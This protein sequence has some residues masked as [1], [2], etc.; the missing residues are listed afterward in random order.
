MSSPCLITNSQIHF[1]FTP[2]AK[3]N[4]NPMYFMPFGAGPRN[5]IGK[6]L[7]LLQ[8]KIAA[9]YVFQRYKL[10]TCD[11]S[12]QDTS[13]VGAH[14]VLSSLVAFTESQSSLHY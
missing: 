13:G 7:A 12:P 2:E 14:T 1:R 10:T 9:A 11:K 5:C 8:A 6:R 4:R 3:A